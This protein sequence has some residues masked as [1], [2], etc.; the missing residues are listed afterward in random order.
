MTLTTPDKVP[1]KFAR[2][3][4]IPELDKLIKNEMLDDLEKTM[5]FL[6]GFFSSA[7]RTGG[8]RYWYNVAGNHEV[9]IYA[10]N[11]YLGTIKYREDG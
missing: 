5:A 9:R 6:D 8:K 4:L 1:D 2:E 11:K 10:D 7:N 3:Q